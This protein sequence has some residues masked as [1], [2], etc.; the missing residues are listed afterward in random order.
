M[1]STGGYAWPVKMLEEPI[2]RLLG[3]RFDL[4]IYKF[5]VDP[6]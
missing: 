2:E 5:E 3:L 6:I 1:S 4:G